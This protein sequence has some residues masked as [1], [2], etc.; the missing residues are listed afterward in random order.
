MDKTYEEHMKD[1]IM[2]E[3]EPKPKEV[4][5]TVKKGKKNG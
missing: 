2:P 4:V 3:D 1:H 5:V